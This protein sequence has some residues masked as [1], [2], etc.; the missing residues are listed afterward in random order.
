MGQSPQAIV[1]YIF[2]ISETSIF[3]N[4]LVTSCTMNSY[5]LRDIVLLNILIFVR[6]DFF[7][8]FM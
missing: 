4:I 3:K 1:M 5:Q 7:S 2:F 6:E 8:I